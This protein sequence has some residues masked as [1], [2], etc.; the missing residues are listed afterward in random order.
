MGSS[1]VEGDNLSLIQSMLSQ[2]WILMGSAKAAGPG[3]R[4]SGSA[5][6]LPRGSRQPS[7]KRQELRLAG[8]VQVMMAMMLVML[9]GMPECTAFRAYNC[10]N[11]S[12]QIK[13]YSLLD[14]EPFGN[15]EKVHAIERDLYRELVQIKKER[16]VQV[17]RCTASQTVKLTYCGF[18]SRS[19]QEQYKK[20]RDPIVI[21]PAACRFKLNDSLSAPPPIWRQKYQKS[22]L[23]SPVR[24]L[25]L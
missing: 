16:L 8:F 14:P 22:V 23:N 9:A 2:R 5:G 13:Q 3:R 21:E 4:H 6:D 12:A 20:F 17:T 19:G 1:Q 7:R 25:S 10:N 24:T 15:M 11:R 18:Q